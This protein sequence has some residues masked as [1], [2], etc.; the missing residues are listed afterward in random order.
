MARAHVA[1]ESK[2]LRTQV[3]YLSKDDVS[4]TISE[5]STDVVLHPKTATPIVE[6]LE[7]AYVYCYK[8]MSILL[9][10]STPSPSATSSSMSESINHSLP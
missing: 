9:R 2:S 7:D 6:C 5:G 3:P 8:S 1:L 4:L 10:S